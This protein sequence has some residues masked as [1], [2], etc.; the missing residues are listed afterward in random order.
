MEVQCIVLFISYAWVD[1]QQSIIEEEKLQSPLYIKSLEDYKL[2][3][4]LLL[5]K[6]RNVFFLVRRISSDPL[7]VIFKV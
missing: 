6:E 7:Y 1:K 5:V 2:R 4:N 3:S